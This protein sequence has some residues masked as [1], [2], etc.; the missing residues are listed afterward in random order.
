V[1]V[2]DYF[3]RAQLMSPGLASEAM[4]WLGHM[5][6]SSVAHEGRLW[7]LS[8]HLRHYSPEVRDGALLGLSF[9]HDDSSVPVIVAA[10][11]REACPDLRQDMLDVVE[12]W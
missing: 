11:E 6:R 12:H 10:S 5:G 8:R 9:L 1:E 3:V 2:L 7:L 4:R